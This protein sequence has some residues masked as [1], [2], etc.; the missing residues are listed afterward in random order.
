MTPD[1]LDY[2]TPPV[3]PP[4]PTPVPLIVAFLAV[5]AVVGAILL[6]V[7][8]VFERVFSE[9]KVDLPGY[10]AAVLVFGRWFRNDYGWIWLAPVVV[11]L[12]I[13]I[14]R[15]APASARDPKRRIRAIRAVTSMVVMV[16][17]VLILASL[18]AG[19][20]RMIDAAATHPLK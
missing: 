12:P 19:W 7:L 5:Y 8:P 13:A 2:Q 14:N 17:A 3:E 11:M 16:L 6:F 10:T 9:F 20:A 1:P 15:L 18:V 4:R